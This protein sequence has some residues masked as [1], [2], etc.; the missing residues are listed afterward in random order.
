MVYNPYATM[1]NRLYSLIEYT[2]ATKKETTLNTSE[3]ARLRE[4]IEL[5]CQALQ[6]LMQFSAVASHRAISRRYRNLDTCRDQLEPLLGEEQATKLVVDIYN[7]W[8]Q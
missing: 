4:Q 6:H 3:V 8:V 7:E 1:Y 5:E 2:H